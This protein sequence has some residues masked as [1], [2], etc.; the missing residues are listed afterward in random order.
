MA[1]ER[2]SLLVMFWNLENFF[3]PQD[4]SLSSNASEK[5]FT[6]DGQKHWSGRRFQTK[7]NA[8]AKT[9][10]WVAERKGRMPEA[11]GVAEVENLYVLRR[12]V[13]STLLRKYEYSIV[14]YDSPD[15]RG[16]DVGLLYLPSRLELLDSRPLKVGGDD[17]KTRDILLASFG[18]LRSGI[19]VDSVALL[20]NHHPSK[21]GGKATS[22]RRELAMQVLKSASDS[23]LACNYE[24][25]VAMGDFNDTPDSQ[26][27]GI[28]DGCLV[29]LASPLAKEGKGTIRYQGKWELIDMFMVSK[30]VRRFRME[31]VHVPFLS[32]RDN[33]HSG[34][35]PL[36]T[37]SGPRYSGGVSDHL[38]IL[39]ELWE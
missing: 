10:F 18:I 2:D 37:Y 15:P 30:C 25:I 22:A 38:P 26:A 29:N 7:C 1:T 3:D 13:N 21:Y 14:H 4:D 27:F 5:Q 24:N 33:A 34:D 20:V 28:L 23:L 36:R 39:L 9:I 19:I 12:L 35:K 31:I 8:I 6:Y 11:I 32:V 16:I 17:F